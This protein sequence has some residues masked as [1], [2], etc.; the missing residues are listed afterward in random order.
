MLCLCEWEM[1][2]GEWVLR[3][4]VEETRMLHG[5]AELCGMEGLTALL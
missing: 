4:S 3:G 2:S 1:L 5:F